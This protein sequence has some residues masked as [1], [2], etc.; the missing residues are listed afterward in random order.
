MLR[1]VLADDDP[2]FLGGIRQHV[3]WEAL[4]LSVVG[5][6]EN[7]EEALALCMAH[8]PD[9]LLT[10]V[11]MPRMNGLESALRIHEAHPDCHILFMSAYAQ[12]EDYRAAI[13]LRA[14]DFLEKPIDIGELTEALSQ[15]AAQCAPQA[16][17]AV[18]PVSR[19]VRDVMR[20][21]DEHFAENL[22]VEAL[23]KLAFFTPNYLSAL[24]RK[25]TGMTISQYETECRVRAAAALLLETRQTVAEVSD[26]VGYRDVRHFSKTFQRAMR[27][28]PSEY[29]RRAGRED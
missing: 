20:H 14:V 25:E 28:T 1:I 24:F 22:S 18:A 15:A 27:V 21:I 7:G 3:Q 9:L 5:V 23:A 17:G 8:K 12:A 19:A 11:R 10:D 4:G 29:R 13:R 2:I 16:D 6:A 26:A